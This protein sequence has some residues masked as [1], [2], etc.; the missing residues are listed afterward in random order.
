[1]TW[2]DNNVFSNFWLVVGVVFCVAVFP[3]SSCQKIHTE[4]STKRQEFAAKH[5]CILIDGD[6]DILICNKNVEVQP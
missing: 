3:L 2:N 6:R 1:M 5:G 4:A